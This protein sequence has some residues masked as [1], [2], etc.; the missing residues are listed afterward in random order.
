MDGIG[1]GHQFVEHLRPGRQLL[2]VGPFLVE[3]SDGL[4]V[5][6]LGIRIFLHRPVEVAQLE[7]QYAFFNARPC[8]LLVAFLVGRDGLHGVALG[9]VDVSDGIVH[10][11]EIVLVVVVGGHALQP[12]D[13]L[14]RLT[15]REH[16][17]H[18]DACI[19]V[20][21]VGRSQSADVVV[22]LV[23]LA[24]VAESLIEL[25]EQEP[26]AGFLLAAHLVF[27][28]L[29][30]VGDGLLVV[31]CV[32]IVVGVGVVPLLAG[33]PVDA[34]ALHVAYHVLGIV[35]PAF[36]HVALGQ[37]GPC[38]PIDGGLGLIEPAHVGKR[39]GGLVELAL[40]ELRTSHEQP[41]FPEKRIILSAVEPFQVAG[42]LL[43]ALR[44]LWATLD[45]V[46]LN[47]LLAFLN[48]PVE[49]ALA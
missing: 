29:A 6:A 40:I 18:G 47:G 9:Q 35:E 32:D 15:F 41:C 20:Q 12:T 5:A 4:A 49:V 17:G 34:V 42:R 23:S 2:I 45:T 3:Q 7:Q 14:L 44:P 33:T 31:A 26:L 48:G 16:F 21:L 24:V 11:V 37:P 1:V 25:S 27:D 46:L 28:H 10:L 36:L 38:A 13:H 8:C 30:Q 22:G 19:E 39:R 43:A